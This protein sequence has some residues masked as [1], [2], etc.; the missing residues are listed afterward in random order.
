MLLIDDMSVQETGN[1][2]CVYLYST[3]Y[4]KQQSQS[5]QRE[6]FNIIK[7]K[8]SQT[9]ICFDICDFYPSIS[10]SLLQISL[11]FAS[12]YTNITEEEIH[13]I[14]Q[15]KKNQPFTKIAIHGQ[16]KSSDFDVT[17]GSFDGAEVCE[18][19]GLYLLSQL[20]RLAMYVGFYRYD[21]LAITNKPPRAVE[22]MKKE[23]CRIFKDNGLNITID[24]NK[25]VVDFLDIT[26]DLRTGNYKPYKK[27]NDCINYIH[28][29]SNHTPAIINN[30]PKGIELR[31]SNNSSDSRLFEEEAKRYNRA[32]KDN[33]HRRELKFTTSPK[34][35]DRTS[36][37]PKDPHHDEPK[38]RQ[39][40]ETSPGSIL[41]SVKMLQPML[42]TSFL[43]FY[44]HASH[45]IISSTRSSTSTR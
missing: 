43:P 8:T 14:T 44:L 7:D 40:R 39:E 15:E 12:Q 20:Q 6:R 41:L 30:I 10:S 18:L 35:T 5:A 37:D 24:A 31:L 16:K 42:E 9:M 25:R 13:I 34:T 23:M 29:E 1:N 45:Q 36:H 27:P 33:G 11:T 19:V 4:G 28:K 38:K 3:R 26:L 32:L 22:N 17:M 2:A 21:G